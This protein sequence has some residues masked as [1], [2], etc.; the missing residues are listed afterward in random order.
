MYILLSLTTV[1]VAAISPKRWNCFWF[2]ILAQ[3]RK[4]EASVAHWSRVLTLPELTP[5]RPG[6]T[7]IGAK[8]VPIEGAKPTFKNPWGRK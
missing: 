5:I 4:G 2:T 8:Q 7:C 6:Y 3:L 1:L